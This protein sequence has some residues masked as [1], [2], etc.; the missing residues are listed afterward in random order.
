MVDLPESRSNVVERVFLLE[1]IRG[2]ISNAVSWPDASS[3]AFQRDWELWSE[4]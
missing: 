1:A 3:R 4:T 2:I